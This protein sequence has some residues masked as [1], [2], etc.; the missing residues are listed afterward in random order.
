[1]THPPKNQLTHIDTDGRVNMVDVGDK[2]VTQRMAMAQ[3][4]V[5]ALPETITLVRDGLTKKGDVMT[6]AEI[7]GVMATKRTA[8]LIPLCHPLPVTSAKVVIE[9]ISD[10]QFKVTARVKTAGQTG[11]EM[12]ALTSVS[13]ACL[14]LYDMLKATD[15]GMVI[16][17]I[18][19]LEKTGGKSGR[20]AKS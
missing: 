1:M 14:T 19:L 18:E 16:G 2:A 7:A 10:T 20:Y 5:T 3:G 12:E 13:V 15:K 11:I 17:P 6:V 8:E 4:F 9:I